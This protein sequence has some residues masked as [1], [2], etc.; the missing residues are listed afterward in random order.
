MIDLE[1]CLLLHP[2]IIDTSAPPNIADDLGD[3]VRRDIQHDTDGIIDFDPSKLILYRPRAALTKNGK[4][5]AIRRN[6]LMTVPRMR[7]NSNVLDRQL[8][9]QYLFEG[10]C[11]PYRIR[12]VGTRFFDRKG[13]ELVRFAYY[14]ARSGEWRSDSVC[15]DADLD[16]DEVIALYGDPLPN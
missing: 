16:D 6:H 15:F 12:Y 7:L 10:R 9:F 4:G 13:I 3:I 11:R 1:T 8:T 2:T 14:H 5:I